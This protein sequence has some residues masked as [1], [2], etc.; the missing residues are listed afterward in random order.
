MR[1]SV[2]M[3]AARASAAVTLFLSL[4]PGAAFAH[5]QASFGRPAMRP[6]I[7]HGRGQAP[8]WRNGAH[9]SWAWRGQNRFNRLSRNGWFWNGGGRYGSG[10][11]YSPYAFADTGGGGAGA[12]IIVT[13][14]S[15]NDF[16]AAANQGA[17]PGSQ[18][19]CVIHKLNYDGAGNYV[20]E[21]QTPGC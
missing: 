4:G 8:G 7:V 20:G 15:F 6:G 5:P 3:R 19:G 1:T 17:D 14:P 16:P 13:A 12:V 10:F 18:G 21:R 2:L 11:W 9:S